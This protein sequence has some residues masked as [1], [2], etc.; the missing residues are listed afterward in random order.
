MGAELA[1]GAGRRARRARVAAAVVL[2]A[3]MALAAGGG[4][5]AAAARPAGF[6]GPAAA[7]PVSAAGPSLAAGT[8]TTVAGGVGGPGRATNV[9]LGASQQAGAQ[10]CGAA[11]G[12]GHLYLGDFSMLR[13]V[14][15]LTGRLTTPAGTGS[16]GPLG[17]GGPAARAMLNGACGVA[18]DPRGNLLAADSGDNRIRLVA[19]AT[20][21]FY[22]QAMAAGDIY[23]V[24]GNG[25]GGNSGNG[26]PATSARLFQPE[27]AAAD[28]AGNLLIGV[29]GGVRVV[30][31]RT[32]T[33]Y[34]QAMTAGDIYN[35]AG[36]G[37][38]GFAGD[39]G[40]ARR[41]ELDNVSGLATDAAGDVV[42]TDRIDNRIRVLRG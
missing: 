42:I 11:F 22:G 9:D 5:A 2:A 25:M 7:R 3:G 13:A 30:A 16:A 32:G 24:A 33:F 31:A 10:A 23:T 6:A 40:P 14:D 37:R 15:P 38:L 12:A 39:G 35:L 19:A 20:G 4:G 1:A 26:G 29:G 18:V 21:T 41:A 8:I 27:A 36:T 34:G 28:A 17:D